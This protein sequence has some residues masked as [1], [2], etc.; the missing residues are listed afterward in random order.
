MAAGHLGWGFQKR[1]ATMKKENQ[2]SISCSSLSPGK[3]EASETGPFKIVSNQ[4]D[5]QP[6]NSPPRKRLAMR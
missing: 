1:N 2:D 6:T 5:F 4:K 3:G